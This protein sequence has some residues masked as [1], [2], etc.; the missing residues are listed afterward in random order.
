[1]ASKLV[2]VSEEF[3][4]FTAQ[5]VANIEAFFT[6][7]IHAA[8]RAGVSD[9]ASDAQEAVTAVMADPTLLT[10]DAK[11]KAAVAH[12]AAKVMT[13]GMLVED[14]TLHAFVAAAFA[15]AVPPAPAPAPKV[16]EPPGQP[17]AEPLT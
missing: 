12:M 1:M 17:A 6:P 15:S 9:F 4:A 10:D 3:L 8:L 14:R 11:R 16:E 2:T 7:L 5:K 13:Q